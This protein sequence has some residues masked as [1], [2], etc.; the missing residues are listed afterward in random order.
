MAALED[1]TEAGSRE[2]QRLVNVHSGS[3]IR[4]DGNHDVAKGLQCMMKQ[5]DGPSR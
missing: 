1:Y 4:G 3:V 2:M 5:V